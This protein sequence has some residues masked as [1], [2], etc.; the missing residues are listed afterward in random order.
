MST[1]LVFL[2][3]LGVVLL[4]AAQLYFPVYQAVDAYW[5]VRPDRVFYRLVMLLAV[6]GFW[7]LL[8]LL[9]INNRYALGY[10]LPLRHFAR[11]M[12]TGLGAGVAIMALHAAILIL[13]GVRVFET[14]SLTLS[15]WL[16]LLVSGLLGGLLVAL[17]EESFFRGAMQYHMRYSNPLLPTLAGTSLFYAAVHFIHPPATGP[18]TQVDWNTG[19]DMLVRTFHQFEHYSGFIDS[20][21]ALFMAGV[22]LAL[23]RERSGSIALC[24]GIHTGWVLMIKLTRGLTEAQAGAPS[25]FLAGSYDG[26]IGWAAAVVLGLATL[27]YWLVGLKGP[28]RT[29]RS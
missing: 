10:A 23:V 15:A 7:P 8:K 22:L 25:A 6:L 18:D 14:D 16:Y 26:V 19:W 5:D 3:Y 27:A 4:L 12:L 21:A 11:A 13:F 1:L 28:A 24:I 29:P 17:I 20:F 2:A 9:G